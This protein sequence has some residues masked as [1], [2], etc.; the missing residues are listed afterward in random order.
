MSKSVLRPSEWPRIV[1]AAVCEAVETR[2]FEDAGHTIAAGLHNAWERSERPLP[3]R[4]PVSARMRRQVTEA[5][6]ECPEFA[7]GLLRIAESRWRKL[8]G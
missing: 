8:V 3:L 5:C 2:E 1:E 6:G 7:R 4:P